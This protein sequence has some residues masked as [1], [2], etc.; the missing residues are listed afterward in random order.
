MRFRSTLSRALEAENPDI[1][2]LRIATALALIERT[3]SLVRL[4][5]ST[6]AGRDYTEA[7]GVLEKLSKA[8][9]IEGTD[10]ETLETARKELS[11]LHQ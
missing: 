7:V 10:V 1:I 9:A 6:A 8:G 11:Q 3:P 2:E 4:S 5:D